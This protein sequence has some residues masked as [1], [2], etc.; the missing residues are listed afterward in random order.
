MLL[1]NDGWMNISGTRSR[2][3]YTSYIVGCLDGRGL[4]AMRKPYAVSCFAVK[5]ERSGARKLHRDDAAH[6][7]I[8]NS[9]HEQ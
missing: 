7:M 5:V 2:G 9:R 8:I 6:G 3:T 1:G 4:V